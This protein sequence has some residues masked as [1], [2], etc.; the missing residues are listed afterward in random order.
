[1][2]TANV[3][4]WSLANNRVSFSLN[5]DPSWELSNRGYQDQE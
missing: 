5:L 4:E 2:W 3:G 1:M